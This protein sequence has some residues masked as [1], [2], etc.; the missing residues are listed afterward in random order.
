MTRRSIL[1]LF[2]LALALAACG[3]R[4]AAIPPALAELHRRATGGNAAAP[5]D[6]GPRDATIT[7]DG[8]QPS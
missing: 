7:V 1:A 4:D 2:L 5:L 8:S 3:D 6:L